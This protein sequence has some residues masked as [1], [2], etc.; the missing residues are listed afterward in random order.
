MVRFA[1]NFYFLVSKLK[2]TEIC[3]FLKFDNSDKIWLN[4]IFWLNLV[5]LVQFN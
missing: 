5:R 2:F 4:L 1:V 3:F